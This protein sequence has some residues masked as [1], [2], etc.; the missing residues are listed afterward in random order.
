MP[1]SV[2]LLVGSVGV[3][4]GSGKEAEAVVEEGDTA[5]LLAQ[6]KLG[7]SSSTT[8][9]RRSRGGGGI[10]NTAHTGEWGD[11]GVPLLPVFPSEEEGSALFGGGTIGMD[12]PHHSLLCTTHSTHNSICYNTHNSTHQRAHW[13]NRISCSLTHH[14]T[15][16]LIS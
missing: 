10:L 9:G 11:D 2:P 8:S 14:T 3:G 12:E 15:L 7:P 4:G 6:G 1:D 5:C 13:H 16:C